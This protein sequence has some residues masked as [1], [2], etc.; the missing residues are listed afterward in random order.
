MKDIKKQVLVGV[1]IFLY[2]VTAVHAQSVQE[3]IGNQLSG[4][5]Q[6]YTIEG[7]TS[8][9][10]GRQIPVYNETYKGARTFVDFF[11]L[12]LLLGNL[13]KNNEQVKKLLGKSGP[14]I[15]ATIL[16]FAFVFVSGTGFLTSFTPLVTNIPFLLTT[17]AIFLGIRLLF[18]K[19]GEEL[20][21]GS[22]IGI[23]IVALLIA[24]AIFFFM[25]KFSFLS[26]FSR[27]PGFGTTGGGSDV[28]PGRIISGSGGEVVGASGNNLQQAEALRV[29]AEAK[30][31][32]AE[33]LLGQGKYQEASAANAAADQLATQAEAAAR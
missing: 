27:V 33:S 21:T 17:A 12:L 22:R 6:W 14:A 32:E 31:S 9:E 16:S 3:S 30:Y 20:H 23:L 18:G 25:N 15:L 13:F 26:P 10:Q 28:P 8:D 29:A 4:I 1:F 7:Y 2:L 24:A 19:K 5:K 11:I